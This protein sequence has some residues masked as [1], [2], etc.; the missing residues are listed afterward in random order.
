MAGAITEGVQTF[1]LETKTEEDIFNWACSSRMVAD[2][3][4]KRH[5]EARQALEETRDERTNTG[6]RG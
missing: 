2:A 4:R 3:F 1:Q 6:A 5:P